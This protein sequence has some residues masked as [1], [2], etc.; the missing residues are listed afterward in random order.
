M[1][2]RLEDSEG[3]YRQLAELSFNA[4]YTAIEGKITYIKRH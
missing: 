4:I 1:N 3:R 2:L